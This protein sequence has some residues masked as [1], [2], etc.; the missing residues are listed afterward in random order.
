M[1]HRDDAEL[2]AVVGF[3]GLGRGGPMVRRM[4]AGGVAVRGY[5][6]A[7]RSVLDMR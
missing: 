4:V 1:A 5:D 7:D 2:P 3:I 6:A